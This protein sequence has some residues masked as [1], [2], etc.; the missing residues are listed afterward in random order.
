MQQTI[1]LRPWEMEDL[2]DLVTY[3]NN[4]KIAQNLTD[5]FPHP[6]TRENGISFIQMTKNMQNGVILCIALDNKVAGSIGLHLQND[7]MRKNAELGYFVAEPFWGKGVCTAAVRLMVSHGFRHFDI[8]RIYA[9]P[10]GRN[11]ASQKVLMNAGFKFEARFHQ[12][13]IKNGV[14]EDELFF[15]IRKEHFLPAEK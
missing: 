1:A 3:A 11:I 8:D 10:F 9:R 5:M 13:I 2:Q 6:Y 15:G 4:P 14:K 12:N 7:I